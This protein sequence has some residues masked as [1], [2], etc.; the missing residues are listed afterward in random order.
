MGDFFFM[1]LIWLVGWLFGALCGAFLIRNLYAPRIFVEN[2]RV[3]SIGSRRYPECEP[4]VLSD[5]HA[6]RALLNPRW[7]IMTEVIAL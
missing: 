5:F 4:V 7:Y 6:A 1:S 3:Y 2:N